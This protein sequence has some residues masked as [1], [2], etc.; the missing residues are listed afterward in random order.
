[1]GCR[2]APEAACGLAAL[3]G[4]YLAISNDKLLNYSTSSRCTPV[5]ACA[6]PVEQR[7]SGWHSI[8]ARHLVLLG[9][10]AGI[11]PTAARWPPGLQLSHMGTSR[12]ACPS[13]F[14]R[15]R[16]P[17]RL[18]RLLHFLFSPSKA[19]PDTRRGCKLNLTSHLQLLHHQHPAAPPAALP[20]SRPA[21][22]P[23]GVRCLG[24]LP[25]LII[26]TSSRRVM[27]RDP[28]QYIVAL[29]G[30]Y[31][32]FQLVTQASNPAAVSR[33]GSGAQSPNANSPWRP[34]K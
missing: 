16:P 24:I 21:K 10:L 7:Q 5:C 8:G 18:R 12:S 23:H 6:T 31:A 15:R 27:G 32:V 28:K 14:V 30:L 20:P 26:A 1:M 4:G 2:R 3:D 9:T 34:Q 22:I 17:P 11:S 19:G 33:H 25:S 13:H 29:V